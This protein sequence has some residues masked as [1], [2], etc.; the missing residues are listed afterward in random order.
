MVPLAALKK[1]KLL[2]FPSFICGLIVTVY[3][4]AVGFFWGGVV[5]FFVVAV[6]AVGAWQE[7]EALDEDRVT[8]GALGCEIFG[9][10]EEGKLTLSW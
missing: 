2:I 7:F 1:W 4:L 10:R 8:L 9:Q 6:W 3:L 5:F